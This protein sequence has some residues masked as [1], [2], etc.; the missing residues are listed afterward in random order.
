MIDHEE[1]YIYFVN[2][3]IFLNTT[4]KQGNELTT[5]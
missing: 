5:T 4:D 2:E 3:G 1:N